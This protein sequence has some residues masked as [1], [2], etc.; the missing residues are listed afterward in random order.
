MGKGVSVECS[1]VKSSRTACLHSLE[2]TIHWE[3]NW[4]MHRSSI[5][6]MEVMPRDT[7]SMWTS[8]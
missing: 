5:D 4:N 7:M 2:F 8:P 1:S 6:E 3:R